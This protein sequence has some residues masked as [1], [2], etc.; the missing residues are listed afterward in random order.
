MADSPS[1]GAQGGGASAPDPE[2]LF[3]IGLNHAA[4][5][6]LDRDSA[7]DCAITFV[8]KVLRK[9]E[10]GPGDQAERFCSYPYLN[11]CARNHAV[12]MA[13]SVHRAWRIVGTKGCAASID[14]DQRAEF[15]YAEMRMT[16]RRAVV[17]LEGRQRLLLY[18]RYVLGESVREIAASL[19]QKPQV[20]AQRSYRARAALRS[21]LLRCGIEL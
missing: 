13:R 5:T 18:R 15:E 19:G 10:S 9:R 1:T 16:L 21:A 17:R 6:G 2:L 3:L 12:D 8:E 20:I 7:Q 4:I 11:V 14:V